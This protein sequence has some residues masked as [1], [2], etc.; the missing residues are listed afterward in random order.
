MRPGMWSGG[1]GGVSHHEGT[2]QIS[3]LQIV[4]S[5]RLTTGG[6]Q[7]PQEALSYAPGDSI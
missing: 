4:C 5:K 7:E 1:G 6:S 2:H 3:T